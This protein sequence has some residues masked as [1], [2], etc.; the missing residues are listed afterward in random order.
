MFRSNYAPLSSCEFMHAHTSRIFH[1]CFVFRYH[2]FMNGPANGPLVIGRVS[3]ITTEQL[4]LETETETE[5]IIS[6]KR[7][8]R[9]HTYT[10][11]FD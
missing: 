4:E 5:P 11:Q 8:I 1:W 7:H 2:K 3:G 10:P 9:S 6:T